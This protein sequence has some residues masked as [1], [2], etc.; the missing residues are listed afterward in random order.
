VVPGIAQSA[1]DTIKPVR[2]N[3]V[4]MGAVVF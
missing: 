2:I 4:I 1:P 3:L